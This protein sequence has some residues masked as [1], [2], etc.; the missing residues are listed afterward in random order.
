MEGGNHD[1]NKSYEKNVSIMEKKKS[2]LLPSQEAP[3][4]P[5]Q[6]A[7]ASQAPPLPASPSAD[8]Q[9]ATS[10]VGSRRC[11]PCLGLP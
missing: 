11:R 6:W 2:G 10:A 8:L 5:Q 7:G 3:A 1:Q 4:A 9:A